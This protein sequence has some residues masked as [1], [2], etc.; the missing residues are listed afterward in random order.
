[1]V[2]RNRELHAR[3]DD[4]DARWSYYSFAVFPHYIFIRSKRA[5][6]AY[7]VTTGNDGKNGICLQPT[8]S[9]IITAI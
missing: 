1:M 3:N 6:P 4:D 8:I 2:L 5:P 9:E 7:Y